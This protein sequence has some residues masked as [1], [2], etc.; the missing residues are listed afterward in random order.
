MNEIVCGTCKERFKSPAL[1]R[2]ICMQ[3]IHGKSPE[4][5]W[6]DAVH[7]FK[8]CYSCFADIE[9]NLERNESDVPVE[10]D[11]IASRENSEASRQNLEDATSS[12]DQDIIQDQDIDLEQIKK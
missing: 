9:N 10:A 5:H 6:T 7:L 12:Q 4:S 11:S 1:K 3:T 8:Y 2:V